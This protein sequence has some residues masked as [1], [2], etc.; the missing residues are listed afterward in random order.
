M[1]G[2]LNILVVWELAVHTWAWSLECHV[3]ILPFHG[4]ALE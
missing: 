3:V 2:D 1:L 4:T